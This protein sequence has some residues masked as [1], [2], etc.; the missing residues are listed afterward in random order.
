MYCVVCRRNDHDAVNCPMGSNFSNNPFPAGAP[1][2]AAP[3][4]PPLPT[5]NNPF[6]W[7]ADQAQPLEVKIQSNSGKTTPKQTPSPNY[8]PG[9]NPYVWKN[10]N[11]VETKS[12]EVIDLNLDLPRI[13]QAMKDN[14][15]PSFQHFSS[16]LSKNKS[17]GAIRKTMVD[18]KYLSDVK[19][20][21]NG[22]VVYGHKMFLITASHLFYEHFHVKGETEMVIESIDRETFLK[23]LLYCYN[24]E[25]KV[26][27]DDVLQMV[28]AAEK[29][30]VRQITNICHG[31]ISK[32]MSPDSIFVIFEKALELDNQLFQKKCLE[33]IGKNEDACFSSKGFSAISLPSLMKIVEACK[34]STE[35]T[36]EIINKWTSYTLEMTLEPSPPPNVRQAVPINA[37]PAGKQPKPPKAQPTGAIQKQPGKK[38]QKQAQNHPPMNPIPG[39]I[40]MQPPNMNSPP[41][42]FQPPFNHFHQPP[43]IGP[44]SFP[45]MFEATRPFANP[46]VGK[47]ITLDDDDDRESIISKDDENVLNMKIG[48]L[49]PRHQM[50]T[51]FSRL[52][53]TCKRSMLIHDIWFTEDLANKCKEFRLTISVLEQNKR[54]DIHNRLISKNKP[55]ECSAIRID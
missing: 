52:D 40:P 15:L 26:S 10:P 5:K 39:F 55:G 47:L 35:K 54:T 46:N 12:R 17:V 36:S 8:D 29:L 19:F 51:E 22:S 41:M 25:I 1:Y 16:T 2:Q 7:T 3:P 14:P 32:M 34:Y 48:V 44:H 42:M 20:L 13:T 49:G 43:P 6:K 21:I 4:I 37:K 38:K 30:Q 28:L 27:E 53:L 9:H 23:V 31:F 18:N 24:S 33:F 50:P 11:S 45:Y